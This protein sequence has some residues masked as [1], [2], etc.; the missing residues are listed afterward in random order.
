MDKVTI[1]V[2]IEKVETRVDK[3]VKI[4]MGSAFELQPEEVA[5]LIAFNR[6]QGWACFSPVEIEREDLDK[7]D[8]LSK[9]DM[10]FFD[11]PKTASQRLRNT[12]YVYW[13]QQGSKKNFKEYYIDMMEKIINHYKEKLED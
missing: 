10:E 4:I 2:R 3:S 11:N 6:S 1:P 12:L 9:D 5:A 8:E 7:L 13:E